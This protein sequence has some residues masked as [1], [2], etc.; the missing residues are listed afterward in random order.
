M[1]HFPVLALRGRQQMDQ[2]EGPLALVEVTEYLLAVKPFVTHQVQQIV[3][4]LER[5]TEVKTE[6]HQRAEFG[7][8]ARAHDCSDAQRMDG[9]VPARLVHDQIQIVVGPEFLD[10]VELPAHFGCLALEGAHRHRVEF[11]PHQLGQVAIEPTGRPPQH[12]S[13]HHRQCITCVEGCSDSVRCS[14][15]WPATAHFTA[16]GDV[17]M[18]QERVVQHLDRHS[19]TQQLVRVRSECAAGRQTQRGAQRLTRPRRIRAHRC[20][21]PLAGFAVGHCVEH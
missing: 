10:V 14:Q 13:C 6:P 2:R 15:S 4:D 16:V 9:G 8:A 12:L 19:K 18:H 5:G 17:V 11:S 20:I 3:A 7:G 1:N 21:E